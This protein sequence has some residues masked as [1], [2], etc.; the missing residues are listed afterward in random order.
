MIIFRVNYIKSKID[1]I[2][3]V[4][5]DNNINFSEQEISVNDLKETAFIVNNDD[6]IRDLDIYKD[7]K[8]YVQN[9]SSMYPALYLYNEIKSGDILDMC[10]APGGKTLH[11]QSISDNAFNIT[12]IEKDKKRFERMKYNFDLEGARVFSKQISG[13]DL[14]DFLKFDA[15]ILDAP[16]TGSGTKKGIE[17]AEDSL[18]DIARFVKIQRKLID[19]AMKLI[20]KG[21]TLL[22]S[23]CSIYK[24]EDEE[25]RDYILKN[26]NFS[27]II[28]KKIL[29]DDIKEGFYISL[30]KYI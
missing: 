6:G 9:I 21:G 7:G 14:D 17:N 8:I 30:F 20:K 12:A 5:K 15:I 11:L 25:E 29:P 10:A 28:D 1:E 18:V 2:E 22:Y 19:K 24:E 4:L 13:T 26:K 27:L 16:C 3:L 23:T